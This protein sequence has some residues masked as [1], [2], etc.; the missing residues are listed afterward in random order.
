MEGPPQM[1]YTLE[2]A[3]RRLA[4]YDHAYGNEDVK[5]AINAAI[6]SLAGLA[7]WECLRKVLRFTAATPVFSLPQGCAGLVRACV[8]GRPATMRGQDF[9]FMQSGPGDVAR[10]PAGFRRVPFGNIIDEGTAPVSSPTPPRFRVFAMADG[11]DEPFLTVKGRDPDGRVVKVRVPVVQRAAYDRTTGEV[12]SGTEPESADV[13]E[14]EFSGLDE[15][16]LGPSGTRYV[17]LYANDGESGVRELAH[18][19]PSVLVPMFRWYRVLDM[20]LDRPVEMLVET[21]IDPLPLIEPTDVLPFPGVDPIEYMIMYAWKMQSSEIDAARKYKEEAA[22]WLKAQEVTNDAVQTE[23]LINGSMRG[24]LGLASM[25][26]VN[27]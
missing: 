10:P 22:G 11:A 18:Y 13:S 2:Q 9:Q 16:V 27:I 25:E 19:H 5:D 24:S 23:L 26:A 4:A 14:Q 7:G 15:V 17:T 21:R 3:C 1:Y 6:Q 20:P 12:V 8:N